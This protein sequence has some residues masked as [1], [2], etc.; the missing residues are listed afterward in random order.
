[1][2]PGHG[3]GDRWLR[4]LQFASQIP[5]AVVPTRKIVAGSGE[6][7]PG[8]KRLSNTA[9]SGALAVKP[10]GSKNTGPEDAK[11]SDD[12]NSDDP[13]PPIARFSLAEAPAWSPSLRT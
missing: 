8:A 2:P 11:V 10:S 7:V 13:L 3:C 9:P 6:T 1:V 12:I 5:A 4:G